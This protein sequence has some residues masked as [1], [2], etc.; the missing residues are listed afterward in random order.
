[1]AGSEKRLDAVP[2]RLEDR[3][4]RRRHAHVGDQHREVQDAE[5][6]R[7]VDRHRIGRRRGLEPDAE[8]D[9]LPVRLRTG[10]AERV[11]R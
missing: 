10:D 6:L 9:D 11:E 1:V 8:E 3:R 7:L 2:G 5:T 4:D